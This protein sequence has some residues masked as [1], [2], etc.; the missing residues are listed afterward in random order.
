M[1]FAP[2]ILLTVI[3]LLCSGLSLAQSLEVIELRHRTV[4]EVLPALLPLLEPGGTLT[5]VNNQLFLRASPRN[6]DDIKQALAAIDK[7]A[8]RLY[9][10][11]AP[12]R[13]AVEQ[14]R[15]V[16]GRGQVVLGN[17][18]QTG[19]E[20]RVWDTRSQRNS[21]ANQ[22][23]QTVDGGRAFIHFGR[24]LPLPMRQV[25]VGP[26]GVVVS[27]SVV[28]RDVGSGFHVEPSLRGD[29]V[30]VQIS[31]QAEQVV[32]PGRYPAVDSQR[33]STT[34]EGR[35]GEWIELGGVGREA[36]GQRGGGFSIGSAEMREGRS[37]WLKV[38][39]AEP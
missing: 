33:L 15:G 38:E 6:R 29:R 35:L 20:L 1:K 30:T 4:D 3:F 25:V 36:T 28:Y 12:D 32:T 27:D 11:V 31:Q 8:R 26:G 5:G 9:I 34:V 37:I 2:R 23:V 10:R 21:S 22:M 24:S 14:D 13:Q 17:S 7:A 19:G 18:Q 39:L 16:E